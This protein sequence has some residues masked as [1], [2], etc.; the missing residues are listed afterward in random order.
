MQLAQTP[1]NVVSASPEIQWTWCK[2]AQKP[3]NEHGV[4]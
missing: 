3:I 2:L 1:V 4:N